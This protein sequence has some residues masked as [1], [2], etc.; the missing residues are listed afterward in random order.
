MNNKNSIKRLIVSLIFSF[1]VIAL[2][3]G[4][5]AHAVDA[6]TGSNARQIYKTKTVTQE[7]YALKKSSSIRCLRI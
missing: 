1:A 2:F 3:F 4:T 6:H 5:V 7:S